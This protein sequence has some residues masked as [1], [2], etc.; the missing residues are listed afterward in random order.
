[1]DIGISKPAVGTTKTC[2]SLHIVNALVPLSRPLVLVRRALALLFCVTVDSFLYPILVL[3]RLDTERC[4]PSTTSLTTYQVSSGLVQNVARRYLTCPEGLECV[5]DGLCACKPFS[6][7]PMCQCSGTIILKA[8]VRTGLG[9]CLVCMLISHL[10][11][12]ISKGAK[13]SA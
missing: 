13:A 10:Y 12:S 5:H 4:V 9:Q 7:H 8:T 11:Q 6:T 3:N 2:T 1:M